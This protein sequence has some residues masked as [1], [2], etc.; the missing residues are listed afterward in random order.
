[1]ATQDDN[2]ISAPAEQ[3]KD[4]SISSITKQI[5][6]F[7]WYGSQKINTICFQMW[8]S[9]KNFYRLTDYIDFSLSW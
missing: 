3:V 6:F 7:Q 5:V 8:L 1:M 4:Y 9:T 2:E